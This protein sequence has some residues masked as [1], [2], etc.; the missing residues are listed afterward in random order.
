[1]GS[2]R[3][4]PAYKAHARFACA[5]ARH[6]W[7]FCRIWT[8]PSAQVMYMRCF[9]RFRRLS[10]LPGVPRGSTD[11][12]RGS[13]GPSW[14]FPGG[15]RKYREASET[16][17]KPDIHDLGTWVCPDSTKWPRMVRCGARQI[18]KEAHFLACATTRHSWPFVESGQ[19]HVP[20]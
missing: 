16:R 14:T 7:P 6:S 18:H 12:E 11:Q 13:Q 2:S 4:L 9:T 8:N 5:T 20:R 19:T 1:M 10:I 17:R 3:A 15:P